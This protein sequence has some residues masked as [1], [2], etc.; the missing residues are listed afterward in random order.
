[1]ARLTDRERDAWRRVSPDSL[2]SPPLRD[3]ERFVA[4]TVTARARYIRFVTQASTF[5][6]GDKPVRFTGDHWKL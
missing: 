2:P 3:G 6:K 1:M 4:P 5:H